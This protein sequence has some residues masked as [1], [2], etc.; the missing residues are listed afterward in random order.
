VTED[1]RELAERLRFER[2]ET[3]DVALW[4]H[5]ACWQPSHGPFLIHPAGCLCPCHGGRQP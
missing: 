1:E 2:H 5:C 3:V 4:P